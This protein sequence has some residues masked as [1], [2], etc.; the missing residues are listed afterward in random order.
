MI[1][2]ET[3]IDHRHDSRRYL[4]RALVALAG[5]MVVLLLLFIRLYFLQVVNYDHYATASRSNRLRLE[6]MPPVRGAITD[7]HGELLAVNVPAFSLSLVPEEIGDLDKLLAELGQLIDITEADIAR[8]QEQRDRGRPFD[9]I[10]L[11]SHLS[12]QERAMLA[13][14][15]HRFNGMRLDADSVRSYPFG[16][17][18][19]HLVGYVGRISA[20]DL[21]KVDADRYRGTR[22]YG[23]SGIENVYEE[24]LH[25]ENSFRVVERNALGRE[26]RELQR[27]VPQEGAP[28]QLTVDVGLQQVAAAA[29]GD[30]AGA[31]VALEPATGAIRALVS[32]PAFD[33]N[34]FVR[35]ISSRAYQELL[36]DPL[37]PLFN[38]VTQGQYPPGSTLKPFIGLAGLEAD[39]GITS[40]RNG[41]VFC[42]GWFQLDGRER[43]YRC[44]KRHGH[45]P[46]DL[47][48]S[49]VQS[50][51]VFFYQLAIKLGID[52]I[53]DYLTRFG[54]GAPTGLN[55][56]RESRG[57]VPSSAWKRAKLGEPW[58]PGETVISG[59]GQGYNSATALQ[60]ARA[61]AV[62]ALRGEDVRPHLVAGENQRV[63]KPV[64]ATDSS[65]STVIDAMTAVVHGSRGTA[66]AIGNDIDYQIAGKTGTAQVYQL[67]QAEDEKENRGE[68][69]KKLQDHALFIAFAPVETPELAVAVIVENG[70]SGSSTAA[71]IARKLF[72]HYFANQ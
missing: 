55:L 28:V 2:R 24:T 44:W 27:G 11:R 58:Y 60:L 48:D 21:Q 12:E 42:P 41:R 56:G 72:D 37:R 15:G 40:G 47:V 6:V 66:R 65:W 1:R 3:L 63:T 32:W 10:V 46:L 67:S 50:C 26:L 8:F 23:K 19:A 25:G 31:I 68:I 61:T 34:L 29:L 69:S 14:N 62:L 52:P 54:F 5:V 70:G 30:Q 51:D 4:I 53:H 57:L 13:V 36:N 71:P 16:P 22:F 18:F 7:R 33:P 9:A 45:G 39:N 20:K 38:R 17:L 43:K 35:G 64:K 59:I 49:I